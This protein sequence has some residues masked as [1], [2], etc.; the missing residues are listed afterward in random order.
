MWIVE[1]ILIALLKRSVSI[2]NVKIPVQL[3]TLVKT[4]LNVLFEIMSLIVLA[5]LAFK[6]QGERLV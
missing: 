1:P 2:G 4:Q 5:Q 3:K 6:D